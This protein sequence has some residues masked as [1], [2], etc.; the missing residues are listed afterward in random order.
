MAVGLTASPA[1]AASYVDKRANPCVG[2]SPGIVVEYWYKKGSSSR[3]VGFVVAT[4]EHPASGRAYYA[5][6]LYKKPGGSWHVGKSWRKAEKRSNDSKS[7]VQA[8]WGSQGHTG[9]KYVKNTQI[10]IQFKGS[11]KKY[12]AT[13]K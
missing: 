8:Y 7:W 10:A 3:G 9:P 4:K 12:A 13:L 6:W 5:R 11:S 1:T 2:C